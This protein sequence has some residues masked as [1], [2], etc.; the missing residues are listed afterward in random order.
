MSKMV[1]H[2][3][4]FRGGMR[5]TSTASKRGVMQNGAP[6]TWRLMPKSL[7]VVVTRHTTAMREEQDPRYL[8]LVYEVCS[9]RMGA[10]AAA[11]AAA[12]A[13]LPVQESYE[14]EREKHASS[15]ALS[16]SISAR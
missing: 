2:P 3:Q 12:I 16:L 8:A 7:S 11:R 1:L 4:S 6:R 14:C 13:P 9:A 10:A 5:G 15:T